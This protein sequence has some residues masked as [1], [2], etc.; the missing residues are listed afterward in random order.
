MQILGI[1]GNYQDVV[2]AAS[3]TSTQS[4][5]NVLVPSTTLT[6]TNTNVTTPTASSLI[7]QGPP[8]GGTNQ[9]ITTPYA[10][11]VQSGLSNFQGPI[12]LAL[13]NNAFA[14]TLRP[15]PSLASS[16]S[17]TF[18]PAVSTAVGRSLV[19]DASGVTSWGPI[20]V[21]STN[22]IMFNASG[23]YTPTAKMIFAF[24][25]VIAGGGGGG[26][27]QTGSGASVG[28]AGGG[29]GY[30]AST[31][32]AATIGASQSVTVGNGGAGGA[33][34][35]NNG[36]GG[37]GSS[38]GTLV[39]ANGGSGGFTNGS[40]GGAFDGT[41]GSP[42]GAGVNGMIRKIGFPGSNSF[43]RGTA[44]VLFVWSGVGGASGNGNN[45]GQISQAGTFATGASAP[46]NTG[47]GGAGGLTTGTNNPSYAGGNGGSGYVLVTEY[48]ST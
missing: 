20:P 37:G 29:G 43:V 38:F 18:P 14:T 35:A 47:A 6:A 10:L 45:T 13:A 26:S 34:G 36:G 23:T 24:V 15:S 5:T 22:Q 40:L 33:V 8:I 19:S 28:G 25:E 27:A 9:T 48:L 31:L 21:G 17:L 11:A 12:A 3:G 46:A 16:Y 30:A 42:G 44:G 4:F 2:T 41:V 1:T 39:S 32:S 7:I